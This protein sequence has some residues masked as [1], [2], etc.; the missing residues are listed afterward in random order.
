MVRRL[1]ASLALFAGLAIAGTALDVHVAGAR[2]GVVPVGA[3]HRGAPGPRPACDPD[4]GGLTLPDGFCATIFADS[5]G[6]A[7]HLAVRGNGD[8]FVALNGRRGGPPGGV[9]ALRDTDGDGRA[10]VTE[11]FGDAGGTGVG[12]FD[13]DLYFAP[14]DGIIR[15]DIGPEALTPAGPGERIVSGLP[16]PGT[17]HAAKNVAIDPTGN[18]YVNIGTPSNACQVE[19]RTPDSPGQDPC[20]QLERRGGVWRFDARTPGQTQEDGTRFAT[21]LRNTFALAIRPGTSELWGTQHGRDGLF[22]LW[23]DRFTAED[24]AE[25]P[26]EEFVHIE[27]GDDFGWPYCYYDPIADRKVLAPEYG[28]DGRE[29]GRC[30]GKKDPE[31]GLPAH[32]APIA[33]AFYT[34]TSFPARYRGG[35]FV[36]FHGSWNRAPLPQGGYNVV[37]IPF[38]N[39]RPTGEWEVFADGFAGEDVSPS[40]AEHRPTGLAVGP[41][42][43]LYVA[44]DSGGRIWKI[45]YGVG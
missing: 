10:D 6:A 28:G 1:L 20:P 21:G 44:D 12:F 13:G 18:M 27:E 32:W 15:Y 43:A 5:V 4:D 17:G 31:I 24:Q 41:D 23:S 34:G 16:G 30:A 42:G 7:R 26:A 39:G 38:A 14:D 45:V 11:R 2:G 36:A 37:F 22:Q 19:T 33:T 25:K 9:L 29:V 35:A 8:V 3:A 40:G